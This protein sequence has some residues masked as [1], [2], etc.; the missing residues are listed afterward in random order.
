MMDVFIFRTIIRSFYIKSILMHILM[1]LFLVIIC[2]NVFCVLFDMIAKLSDSVI[3]IY[4]LCL[5]IDL[6]LYIFDFLSEI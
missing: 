3:S 6:K 5:Y 4:F 1:K 2:K